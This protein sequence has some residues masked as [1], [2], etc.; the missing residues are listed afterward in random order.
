LSQ[1]LIIS[2]GMPRAGSGWYYNLV[3]DLVVASGGES[4]RQIR[5]KYHL[6]AFLTEINCNISTLS[7]VRIIPVFVPTLFGNEF[8]IKTHAGPTPFVRYLIKKYLIRVVYI[9]RDP[10]AALLSAY[11]YGQKGKTVGRPNAFSH[12]D[13]LDDAADF[14]NFYVKIWE[15]WLMLDD[16]LVIRYEDLL[17]D[18]NQAIYATMQFL[19]LDLETVHLQRVVDEYRPEMGAR[20]RIGTHYS[21]GE[22]ERFRKVLSED[23]LEKFTLM[24]KPALDRMGYVV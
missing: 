13:T 22:P 23:E 2:A 20:D 15:A 3:H 21:Q 8:A 18:Y 16:V 17:A 5:K 1:P 9:Y 4:A 11:E 7:F 6:E 24:L 10:R 14:I 12:L 19:N